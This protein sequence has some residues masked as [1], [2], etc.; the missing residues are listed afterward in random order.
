MSSVDT[1]THSTIVILDFGSQYTQVIA[2]RI[3]ES[4]VYSEI[5]PFNL[6]ADRI[7][8][9]Q[10][11]G[12]VLSGG[13]AS[14]FATGAPHP[15]PAIFSL[16]VPVLGICYGVHL[17]ALQ[18]NGSV[19]FS[20]RREFGPGTLKITAPSP[21]FDGLP[22]EFAVWNSHGDKVVSLPPG[23][24]IVGTSENSPFAAIENRS[25]NL[26]GLQFH[27]EVAHTPLGKE[28][29]ENFIYKI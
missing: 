1:T 21:L 27:P 4:R 12:I 22:S 16:G 17:M 15:D 2:R 26:F 24:Q 7:Q 9:L 14:V 3:R 28:I 29:L 6:S 25:R 11:K 5:V 23:F 10:P 8:K 18:L 19:E 13:P 20:D